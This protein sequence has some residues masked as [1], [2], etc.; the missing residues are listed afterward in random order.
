M[1]TVSGGQLRIGSPVG[2]IATKYVAFLDRVAADYYASHDLEDLITVIDGREKII[3]EVAVP[4]LHKAPIW[5]R[6]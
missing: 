3:E 6:R 5:P 4:I 1:H 2:F